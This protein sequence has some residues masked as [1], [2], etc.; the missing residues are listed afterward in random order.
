MRNFT[1]E[2]RMEKEQVHHLR[3]WHQD[4]HLKPC[5]LSMDKPS[6]LIYN[7]N[8]YLKLM[9]FYICFL[10]KFLYLI[11]IL[12]IVANHRYLLKDSLL[13]CIIV[14]CSLIDIL[15]RSSSFSLN[16]FFQDFTA[17]VT[18]WAFNIFKVPYYNTAIMI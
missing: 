15:I 9:D 13:F 14:L 6:S 3:F 11:W 12:F 16:I 1:W 2:T 8:T 5:Y 7:L 17:I 10:D 18:D 4:Y